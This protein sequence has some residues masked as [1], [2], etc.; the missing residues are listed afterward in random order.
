MVLMIFEAQSM[1]FGWN[2]MILNFGSADV[3]RW[4]EVTT[5]AKNKNVASILGLGL[6]YPIPE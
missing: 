1:L 5:P 6:G 3:A 2:I 4:G